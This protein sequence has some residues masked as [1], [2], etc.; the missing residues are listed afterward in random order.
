MMVTS[1]IAGTLVISNV[2]SVSNVAAISLSTEFFAPG[3]TT[4]PESGPSPRRAMTDASGSAQGS[5]P[6]PNS[7]LGPW[8]RAGAC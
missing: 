3:T 7:M 4:L 6:W 1:A 2:P 5:W 8:S